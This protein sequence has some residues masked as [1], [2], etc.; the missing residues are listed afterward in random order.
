[1]FVNNNEW[2]GDLDLPEQKIATKKIQ[3]VG[4]LLKSEQEHFVYVGY[5]QHCIAF[6]PVFD[7]EFYAC[8]IKHPYERMALPIIAQAPKVPVLIETQTALI[9]DEEY[10][11]RLEEERQRDIDEMNT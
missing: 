8:Q 7:S 9:L 11:R 3:F 5:G 6:N 4:L 2:I 10:G 1:M